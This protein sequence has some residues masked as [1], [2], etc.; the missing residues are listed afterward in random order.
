MEE[1]ARQGI[2]ILFVS[3]EMRKSRMATARSHARGRI[4]GELA[5]MS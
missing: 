5:P 3:S 4:A 1:L 2:A